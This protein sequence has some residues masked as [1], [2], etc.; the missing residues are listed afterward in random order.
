MDD[1]VEAISII[2]KNFSD[3]KFKMVGS[4]KLGSNK[5][6]S[7]SNIILKKFDEIGSRTAIMGYISP[8]EL[9]NIMKTSS[10]IVI[11]SKWEEPFGLVAAEAMS[12]GTAIIASKSGGLVEII[13]NNGILIKNINKYKIVKALSN[14]MS[15]KQILKNYQN[16]SWDNFSFRSS[17]SSSKLDNFRKQILKIRR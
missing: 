7:F 16:L 2:Y 3:W 9:K 17:T 6:D 11:P 4:T 14:L 10:I 15:S 1:F 8:K 12:Y 13:G 5:L